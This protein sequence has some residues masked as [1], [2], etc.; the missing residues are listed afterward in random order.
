[1]RWHV[2]V[3]DIND[4]HEIQIIIE[5]KNITQKGA[6][7]KKQIAIARRERK[8]EKIKN[9]RASPRGYGRHVKRTS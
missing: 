5:N 6:T 1:M 2:I 4:G 7:K 9:C 3:M 8:S